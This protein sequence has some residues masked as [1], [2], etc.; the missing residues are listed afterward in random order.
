[1]SAASV[2]LVRHG[3]T[4]YNAAGRVQGNIDI[5][6]DETGLWQVEQTGQA[7]REL[8]V[9]PGRRQ[10]V[11]SSPLERALQTARAFADP[12]GLPIH[13][14][15]RLRERAFGDFE[16]RSAEEL[17]QAWP[18]DFAL[19]CRGLGGEMNHHAESHEHVGARGAA[20]VSEWSRQAD[21]DTDLFVFAHGALIENTLQA[22]FGIAQRFPD[23]ISVTTMDNAHWARLL[24]AGLEDSD[25]WIL[26][27]YNH[28]PALAD[29]P[30]WEHPQ[31][32]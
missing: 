17:R 9:R 14:D 1:M 6:L 13:R 31:S 25:R 4:G 21:G 16:G 8:Y 2:L 20:A 32:C 12:L 29:T 30:L 28:G 10:L 22:M 18:E 3:R 11:V 24:D 19:W 23:F 5:P 26:K 7:L 15:E 27:D